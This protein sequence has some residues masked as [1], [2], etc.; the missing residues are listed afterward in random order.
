MRIH[1]NLASQNGVVPV[2]RMNQSVYGRK[3]EN[4]DAKIMHEDR[5]LLSPQGKKNRMM[6][7]LMKQKTDILERKESLMN[8]VKKDGRSMESVKSQ[9]ESLDEQLESIDRQLAEAMAKEM[10]KQTDKMKKHGDGKPKTKEDIQNQRMADI[11]RLSGSLRQAETVDSAKARADGDARVLKSEIELDRGRTQGILSESVIAEKEA[12]LSGMHEKSAK[13]A[14]ALGEQ[15][16][17][18]EEEME[19]ARDTEGL[20]GVETAG[21]TESKAAISPDKRLPAH[22]D[23]LCQRYP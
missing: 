19:E 6:D 5:V 13:L 8:S 10:E 23:I 9:L 15:I 16:A 17:D 3:K 4:G 12:R 21:K 14:A 2:Y 7:M 22:Q 20:E 11:T 18:L 1:V